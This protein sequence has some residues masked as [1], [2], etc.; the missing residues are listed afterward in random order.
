MEMFN[1]YVRDMLNQMVE[2]HIGI[3]HDFSVS[4]GKMGKYFKTYLS[5]ELYEQY[6]NTYC[7]SNYES[8]WEAVFTACDLFRK[9]ALEVAKHFEYAISATLKT[10]VI[11]ENEHN[12]RP[13]CHIS[14]PLLVSSLLDSLLYFF[15]DFFSSFSKE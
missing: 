13:I 9:L 10:I 15:K 1:H 5:G 2:W 11:V 4:A 6:A 3:H 8:V 14:L 12:G 7:N